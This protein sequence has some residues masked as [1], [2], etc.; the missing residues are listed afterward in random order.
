VRVVGLMAMA[1]PFNAVAAGAC[2]G[3]AVP[4]VAVEG[5]VRAERGAELSPSSGCSKGESER[6]GCR[7]V[8]DRGVRGKA[9]RRAAVPAGGPPGSGSCWGAAWP[10]RSVSEARSWWRC[11]AASEGGYRVHRWAGR[12]V[13][14][15]SGRGEGAFCGVLG[16]VVLG[17][18]SSLL[19]IALKIFFLHL[20]FAFAVF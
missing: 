7:G 19:R 5:P 9:P 3:A 12:G 16:A 6:G 13:P 14:S 10:A 2:A 20:P 4:R 1:P 8:T 17:G 15:S 11:G 18:F